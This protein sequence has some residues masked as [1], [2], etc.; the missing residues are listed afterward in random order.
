MIYRD[1]SIKLIRRKTRRGFALVITVSLMVL[2]TVLCLGLLSLSAIC[3]R[4][5]QRDGMSVAQANARMA[6]MLALGE[7]Q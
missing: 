5:T 4:S 6:L 7:L 2:L 1:T 3:L